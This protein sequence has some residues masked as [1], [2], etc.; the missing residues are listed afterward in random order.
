MELRCKEILHFRNESL[1]QGVSKVEAPTNLAKKRKRNPTKKPDTSVTI[2][3]NSISQGNLDVLSSGT[4]LN[5]F[6]QQASMIS[7]G[8]S[9]SKPVSQ[10]GASAL[11]DL[12]NSAPQFQQHVRCVGDLNAS[13]SDRQN[14]SH[15]DHQDF[16]Q[17]TPGFQTS[18]YSRINGNGV[19]SQLNLQM[20]SWNLDS[21]SHLQSTA[22]SG[23]DVGYENGTLEADRNSTAFS[24]G[25]HAL[26]QTENAHQAT[27]NSTSEDNTARHM[28]ATPSHAIPVSQGIEELASM[29]AQISQSTYE[30]FCP[31]INVLNFAYH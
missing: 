13:Q 12:T 15:V 5:S 1:A 9:M 24:C 22:H 26:P 30:D 16:S 27:R 11:M 8:G 14:L 17:S 19:P 6:P 25:T 23:Q 2:A 18:D 3:G 20:H 4:E 31:L 21:F 29:E 28:A 10:F 7:N